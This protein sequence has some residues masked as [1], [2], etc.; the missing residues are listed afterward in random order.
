MKWYFYWV[1]VFV[2]LPV[3]AQYI[4]T[5]LEGT[6]LDIPDTTNTVSWDNTNTSYPNDDD[7]QVVNIGFDFTFGSSQYSQVRIL[8]NGI[9]HFGADQGL[10]RDYRNQPLPTEDGDRLIAV[11]WDDLVDDNQSSVTYGNSGS[12]PNRRFIVNWNNVRAYSNN[13]RYDFQVVLYENGDIRYRY[14]NNTANGESAT[15]GLEVNNSESVQYSYNTASVA[16]SFDLLFRNTL[17][18]LPNPVAEYRFDEVGYD[19]TPAEV[20]DSSG[21]NIHADAI[22]SLTTNDIDP[23]LGSVVGTCNYAEFNGVDQYAE[24]NDNNLID[25]TNEFSAAAWIKIDEI[26]ASGLKTILSKDEN[27]EFHVNSRGEINWWWQNSFGIV[28]GL[29]SDRV[30]QPGVWTHIAISYEPGNQ[31]IYIDGI[32]SGNRNFNENLRTN[33]DPLQFG[34]DQNFSGRQ[35]NGDIDEINIFS[36]F[37]SQY[38]VQELMEKTRPCESANLCISSFPDGLSTHSENGE[39]RFSRDSQLFFSPDDRLNTTVVNVDGSSTERSCVA[40]ECSSNSIPAPVTEAP[41]FPDTSGSDTDVFVPDGGTEAI[42]GVT[43]RYRNIDVGNGS[44]LQTFSGRNDFYIDSLSSGNDSV[45]NLVAANYWIRD[46]DI[47]RNNTINIIGSGTVRIYIGSSTSIERGLIANSESDGTSRDASQLIIYGY[48]DIFI[49]RESTIS[50][51]LYSVGDLTIER[52]SF[53]Y[54]AATASD[55]QLGQS[56]KVYFLQSAVAGADFGG[57]CESASCNLGSFRI[58]QPDFALAC[59]FSRAAIQ[60]Q[61]VC[62]DGSSVKDDYAGTINLTTNENNRSEFYL[63]QTGGSAVSSIT[64]DGT[65]MGS[66]TL[67]LFHQNENNSLAVTA[68]DMA[69]GVV[70]QSGDPT[71]FRTAGLVATPVPDFVCGATSQVRLTAVGEDAA[72]TPCQT[73]TGFSGNKPFKVWFSTDLDSNLAGP[74]LASSALLMDGNTIDQQQAPPAENNLVLT[75]NNGISDVALQYNN[76]AKIEELNFLHDADPY[77]TA[78]LPDNLAVSVNPFVIVPDRLELSINT[79]NSD[80]SSADSGCSA[81]VA[82]ADNFSLGVTARCLNNALA[83]DYIGRVALSH[84]LVSPAS[85]QLGSLA[86]SVIDVSRPDA[87]SVTFDQSISEVGVFDLSSTPSAYFSKTIDTATLEDIGRFYPQ[88][89]HLQSASVTPACGTF[90]YMGDNRLQTSYQVFAVNQNGNRTFNYRDAFAFAMPTLVAENNNNGIDLSARLT[91]IDTINWINGELRLTDVDLTFA[92]P[93]TGVDGPYQNLALGLQLNDND[94]SLAAVDMQAGSSGNCAPNCDARQL[95]STDVRFGSLY[96]AN[97]FGPETMP[98]QQRLEAQYFDGTEFIVNADDNGCFTLAAN[99]PPITELSYQGD[100]DSGETNISVLQTI[101][102][103]VGF[104]QYSA[105]G[106]GN[107]GQL[108]MSYQVPAWLQTENSADDAYDDDPAASITFGQFRGH[109]RVIYWREIIR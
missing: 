26:P 68:S 98:L 7:K 63:G 2:C 90:S 8:T 94:A 20:T 12:E 49:N 88:A 76:S 29:D 3:N 44:L 21:N 55:I 77:G 72:G 95:G 73:L 15:I 5:E 80:C 35:F 65:E 101:S 67:Y 40:V 38:Q 36:Q 58:N 106:V 93:A 54:G 96:L 11:Y 19:G 104:L 102:A 6:A 78:P 22:N 97:V 60:I 89:F 43:N 92:R 13:L 86:T 39:I 99:T 62:D 1:L 32:P 56:S 45:L 27:Y 85:G 47:G 34:S 82:A 74:E 84:R 100:L 91:D 50:A 103:G 64:L 51:A 14:D 79:A 17:L 33:S 4:L 25:F 41:E 37:L 69:N 71:S 53:L 31:V 28:R 9:L 66:A 61:A 105:P 70:S 57:L 52:N 75:F 107:S 59:P 24:V 48:G 18:V 16:T 81:F 46:F 10:H 83:S 42:G 23:A 87:G 109:D 30:I 108:N